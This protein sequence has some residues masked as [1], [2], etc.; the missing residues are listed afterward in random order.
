MF[1]LTD[2]FRRPEW[3][4]H[5]WVEGPV[6]GHCQ[7]DQRSGF[8]GHW[9]WPYGVV[10]SFPW[11]TWIWCCSLA[12][13]MNLFSVVYCCVSRRTLFISMLSWYEIVSKL[14]NLIFR[15]RHETHYGHKHARGRDG[16][17]GNAERATHDPRTTEEDLHG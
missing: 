12:L 8:K 4:Q 10:C 1:I 2:W 6:L 15:W 14:K 5:V 3:W 9:M 17:T 7:Q 16:P 11:M 13:R